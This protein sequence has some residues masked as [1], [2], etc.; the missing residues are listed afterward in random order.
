VIVSALLVQSQMAHPRP[1]MCH[2]ISAD[3]YSV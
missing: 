1:T 2:G 3:V